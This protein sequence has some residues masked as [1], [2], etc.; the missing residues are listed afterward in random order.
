MNQEETKLQTRRCKYW[1]NCR[2]GTECMFYH[3]PTDSSTAD[4]RTR[5]RS[6]VVRICRF[7][8]DCHRDYCSFFHPS[9]QN[10]RNDAIKILSE[11]SRLERQT[12]ETSNDTSNIVGWYE[13]LHE[14]IS[15]IRQL[16]EN[17]YLKTD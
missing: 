7:F 3:P 4:T 15:Q 8:P 5:G 6:P 2:N 9:E 14:R 16:F 12:A 17:T 1:P 11:L 13:N 10:L